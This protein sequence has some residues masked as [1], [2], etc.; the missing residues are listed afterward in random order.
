MRPELS[1][2]QKRMKTA[3]DESEFS[4]AAGDGPALGPTAHHLVTCALPGGS[5]EAR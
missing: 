3:M 2:R 1:Q 5:F 4:D